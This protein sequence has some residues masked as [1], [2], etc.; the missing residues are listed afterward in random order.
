MSPYAEI[1]T[2]LFDLVNDLDITS[3]VAGGWAEGLTIPPKQVQ[4]WPTFAVYPATD[5]PVDLD[6]YNDEV[7]YTFWIDLYYSFELAT[8]AELTLR[9]LADL[10]AVAVRQQ[11]RATPPLGLSE[12][13]AFGP[14]SGTWGFDAENG[15]R[16]YRLAVT[17]KV[18]QPLT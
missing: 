10:V 6:N 11:K 18:E 14:I 9:E 7:D 5:I 15:L 4:D 12:A 1:G 17:I 3:V 8:D 13:F 2:A 16:L